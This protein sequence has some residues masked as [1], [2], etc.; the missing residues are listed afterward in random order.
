M[1]VSGKTLTTS[2]VIASKTCIAAS[3]LTSV[4][5]SAEGCPRARLEPRLSLLHIR[6]RRLRSP[7]VSPRTMPRRSPEEQAWCHLFA[8]SYRG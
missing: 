3:L 4:A 2:G 6:D 1:V 8:R 5:P 7:F